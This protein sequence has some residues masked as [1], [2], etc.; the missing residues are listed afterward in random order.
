MTNKKNLLILRKL[1]MLLLFS[2][3]F[4]LPSHSQTDSTSQ[5]IKITGTRLTYPIIQKWIDEYTLLHP[6]V[7]ILV[8]SKIPASGADILIVSHILGPQD[9]KE[10][11]SSIALTRYIQLPIVTSRRDDIAGLQSAGFTETDFKRI[12]FSGISDDAMIPQEYRFVVYK[13]E[14]SACASIAFAN[15][16]GNQQKD[17]DGIGVNGDDRDLLEAVKKDVRGISYNNLGFIYDIKT[18]KI[19]DSIAIVPIDF[20]KNGKIDEDEKIYNTLDNVLDYAEKTK[21][22]KLLAENVHALFSKTARKDVTEFLSWILAKGQQYNHAYGFVNLDPRV[23]ASEQKLISSFGT[24]YSC[25][26]SSRNL[27]YKSVTKK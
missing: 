10:T 23:I 20:N 18:R 16:F 1:F 13:R 6:Q 27:I 8:S 4:F 14:K 26:P 5:V 21:S 9:V 22:P 25:A 7:K 2:A 15:H 11:Q 24:S 12:Y 17:I 19:V 3:T